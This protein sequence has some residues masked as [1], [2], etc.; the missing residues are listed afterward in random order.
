MPPDLRIRLATEDDAA[1][2]TRLF[3]A[4]RT[5]CFTFFE[6]T[7]PFDTLKHLF[8]TKWIPGDGL[9]VAEDEG[10]IAGF[11]RLEGTE[12]DALYVLPRRHG[13]GVGTALLELA[14][15]K[16]PGELWLWVF[17]K[18]LQARRFYERHGFVL[19]HETNGQGNMEKEPDARYVWKGHNNQ[20]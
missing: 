5:E 18:N 10:K 6:I 2:L 13:K 15:S 20:R 7:Y 17:Q 14:K 8:E 3:I 19:D 12:F 11:M 1:E 4:T 16:S 9:W